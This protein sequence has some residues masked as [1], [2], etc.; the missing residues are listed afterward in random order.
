MSRLQLG[1]ELE[2]EERA[3]RRLARIIISPN[4]GRSPRAGIHLQYAY[5]LRS[6][7]KFSGRQLPSSLHV[8]SGLQVQPTRARA[9]HHTQA[10]AYVSS[11]PCVDVTDEVCVS[12]WSPALRPC[13]VSL[14]SETT[15]LAISTSLLQYVRSTS[16]RYQLVHVG[17]I[18]PWSTSESE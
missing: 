7:R 6:A 10:L 4:L 16:K 15:V 13:A 8:A 11:R 9:Q 12:M 14:L 1:L 18:K 5:D 17:R 3:T 2:L